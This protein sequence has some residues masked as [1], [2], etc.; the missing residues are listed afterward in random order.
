M[1]AKQSARICESK[2]YIIND[3]LNFTVEYEKGAVPRWITISIWGSTLKF[4][5]SEMAIL[6][7][8]PN[9]HY[10]TKNQ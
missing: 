10:K 8:L 3:R 7:E 5:K 6:R 9:V 1:G 4:D 2:V